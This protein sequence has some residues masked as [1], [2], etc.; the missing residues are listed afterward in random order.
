MRLYVITRVINLCQNNMRR[1]SASIFSVLK[2]STG[3]S[4]AS[5]FKHL[6]AVRRMADKCQLDYAV[7]LGG[8]V[9]IKGIVLLRL[10]R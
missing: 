8:T 2:L 4:T 6:S 5:T 7:V 10:L 3:F 9:Y 1:L